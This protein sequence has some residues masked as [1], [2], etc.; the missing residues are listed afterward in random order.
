MHFEQTAQRESFTKLERLAVRIGTSQAPALQPSGRPME[1]D[2]EI[3][4]WSS[5]L[6]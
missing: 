2:V 5:T 3:T 6:F 1:H 4:L